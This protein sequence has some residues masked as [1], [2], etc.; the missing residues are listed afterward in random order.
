V[1][2]VSRRRNH[3]IGQGERGMG[4]E[5][6]TILFL[7][8]RSHG[9][10]V[11][12]LLRGCAKPEVTGRGNGG[13]MSRGVTGFPFLNSGIGRGGGRREGRAEDL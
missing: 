4:K 10:E 6:A 9:W 1:G 13:S 3:L 11:I 12:S 2:L 5:K 8:D 7:T